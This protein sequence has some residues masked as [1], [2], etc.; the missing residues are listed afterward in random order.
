MLR[1]EW[2]VSGRINLT[3]FYMRRLK[4]LLPALALMVAVTMILSALLLSPLGTQQIAAQIAIGAMLL[5]A[6]FVIVRTTGNY[7]DA[8]AQTNPLLSTWSLSVEEQFYLAFPAVI[9]FGWYLA[10]RRGWLRVG[11]Y[12]HV[13]GMTVVSFSLDV[14]STTGLD[15]RGSRSLLG[16]GFYSPPNASFGVRPRRLARYRVH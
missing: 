1:R 7:F 9:S 5:L 12:L 11:P 13:G 2:L 15:F 10:R 14:L 4:R 3:S 16:L 6:N 8:P